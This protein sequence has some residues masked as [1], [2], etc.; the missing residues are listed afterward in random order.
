MQNQCLGAHTRFPSLMHA[1]VPF[2]RARTALVSLAARF[3]VARAPT[4][5]NV[6]RFI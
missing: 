4:G 5:P 6:L 2:K 3:L 1:L